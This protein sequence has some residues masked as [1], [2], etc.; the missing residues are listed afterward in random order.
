LAVLKKYIIIFFLGGIAANSLS[1]NDSL[2]RALIEKAD[3]EPMDTLREIIFFRIYHLNKNSNPIIARQYVMKAN[4]ILRK[5]IKSH[6]RAYFNSLIECS[7]INRILGNYTDAL[8]FIN[9]AFKFADSLNNSALTANAYDEKGLLSMNIGDFKTAKECFLKEIRIRQIRDPKDSTIFGTYNNL[10]IIYAQT[11][12]MP[13]AEE[14]FRLAL[15][16]ALKLNHLYSLGNGYN[17]MGVIKIMQGK[18]DSVMYFLDKGKEIRQKLNDIPN[19]S[20]SYNN[21]A[22]YYNEI[23][24]YGMALNY[25]DTAMQLANK[26][27]TKTELIEVLDTYYKIY[28]KLDD[29]RNAL[30]CYKQ[31]QEILKE[32]QNKQIDKKMSEYESGFN[33]QKKQEELNQSKTQLLLKESEESKQKLKINLMVLMVLLSGVGI[34]M[35]I[36]RNKKISSASKIISEQKQLIEEKHKDITDSINYAQKIQTALIVSEKTLSSKVDNVFVMFKPRDIVSGDFYWFGEKNDY[37][38]LAVADCTGHGVPG[39]FMSMIGITLLNQIVGE[40]GITSPSAILNKLREGIISSLNQTSEE[41]G[42]RDGMDVSLIAWNKEELIYA[43]ANNPCI[44]ISNNEIIELKPNKQPVG[45]YEK[46]EP[47]TEQKIDLKTVDS[48]YLF[49]DGIVDQFGGSDNKKVKVKLF[50]EWLSEIST[51]NSARQK[52]EL[53]NKFSNWKKDIEQTD[54]ILVIGIKA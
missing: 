29:Y 50:K 26:V 19:L 35:V 41:A 40:K 1:Q 12:E 46:Q 32:I 52:S 34:F 30:R 16:N 9:E 45:L 7:V 36:N 24:K 33:L 54:D 18:L 21:I 49:T 13:K 14:Y 27:Q 17:N 5:N 28:E 39:A 8:P 2:T 31:R 42:K 11:G 38:L 20:G 37:K 44:V 4:E 3:K 48:I 43:G 23:K 51:Y 22:L 47:F 6:P 25:A 53:E 15:Q 10:A